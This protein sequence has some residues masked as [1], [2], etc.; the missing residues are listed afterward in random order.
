MSECSGNVCG[1]GTER[2]HLLHIVK[3]LS[4]KVIYIYIYVLFFGGGGEGGS[5]N[6]LREDPPRPRSSYLV[7]LWLAVSKHR[8]INISLNV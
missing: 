5:H 6:I 2:F 3:L 1:R 8:L 4:P 7:L